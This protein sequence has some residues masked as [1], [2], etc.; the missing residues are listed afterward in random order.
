MTTLDLNQIKDVLLKQRQEIVARMN[1]LEEGWKDLGGRE[2]ETEEEAQKADLTTLY[3]QLDK[4][5]IDEIEA[6]DNALVKLASVGY[7]V[8]EECKKSIGESRLEVLPT[9]RWCKSCAESKHT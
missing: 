1:T 8:C 9:T 7:G 3:D 4:R 2:V 5:E 6:I